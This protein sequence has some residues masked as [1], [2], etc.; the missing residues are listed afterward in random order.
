MLSIDLKKNCN[1]E[2]TTKNHFYFATA[3]NNYNYNIE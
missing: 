2:I 3:N 1:T